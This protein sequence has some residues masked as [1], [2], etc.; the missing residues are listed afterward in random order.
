LIQQH[1][2]SDEILIT[3]RRT[4]LNAALLFATVDE[5]LADGCQTAHEVL[6]HLVFWH[7]EYVSIA[8]ALASG[9]QPELRFG[10][11]VELN[12]RAYQE[13]AGMSLPALV[14]CLVTLQELL[15]AALRHLPDWEINFPVKQGGRYWSIDERLLAIES[16]IYRHVA[17]LRHAARRR[18]PRSELMA[19]EVQA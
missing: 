19:R 12:A 10:T 4:V 18:S 11:I 2:R 15:E 5:R 6:A 13:F 3:L 16:H 14:R 9:R 17:R 1:Q 8:Q 7:R